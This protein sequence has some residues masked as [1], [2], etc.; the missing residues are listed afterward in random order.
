VIVV[1]ASV[2]AFRP[3]LV[4]FRHHERTTAPRRPAGS[5]TRRAPPAPSEQVLR[6][7]AVPARHLGHDRARRVGRRHGSSFASSLR[8][9][10]RPTP[11]WIS[12]RPRGAGRRGPARAGLRRTGPAAPKPR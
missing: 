8:R 7:H 1:E 2:P 4:Q 5:A 3:V 12:T 11:T 10:R 6:R 9:R